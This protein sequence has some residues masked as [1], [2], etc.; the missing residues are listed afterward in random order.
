M[1]ARQEPRVDGELVLPWG[2]DRAWP[3]WGFAEPGQSLAAAAFGVELSS[4]VRAGAGA[5]VRQG[6]GRGAAAG[7]R[8]R[9]E[10]HSRDGPQPGGHVRR[11]VC[12]AALLAPAPLSL[13]VGARR[14]CEGNR[15][16]PREQSRGVVRLC[17]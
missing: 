1:E 12:P 7:G 9:D 4:P 11:A 8:L 16:A 17:P 3:Q 15:S 14:V 13:C 6:R 10:E 5:C 2:T